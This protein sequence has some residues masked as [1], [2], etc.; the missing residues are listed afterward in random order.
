[1]TELEL[2]LQPKFSRQQHRIDNRAMDVLR[3]TFAP[4]FPDHV[5]VCEMARRC[6]TSQPDNQSASKRTRRKGLRTETVATTI[7]ILFA[8]PKMERTS[9][10]R[11]CVYRYTVVEN[12]KNAITS[13]KSIFGNIFSKHSSYFDTTCN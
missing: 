8:G 12:L 4:I 6:T 11:S 9:R 2:E 10:L 3:R 1:M 7:A 13:I 5:Y